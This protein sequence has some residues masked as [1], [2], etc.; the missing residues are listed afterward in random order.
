MYVM[1]RLEGDLTKKFLIHS[2]IIF[3]HFFGTAV[4]ENNC[5]SFWFKVQ[6]GYQCTV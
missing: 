2:K 6:R 4:M 1:D 5:V 3:F